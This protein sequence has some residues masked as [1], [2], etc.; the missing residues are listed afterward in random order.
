[1]K[2]MLLFGLLFLSSLALRACDICGGVS[3]NASIGLFA[4]SSF[5]MLGLKTQNQAFASYLNGIRH[6]REL[7][8]RHEIQGRIQVSKR[9][10]V[11][12]VI[13]YQFAWQLR[14]LGSDFRSGIGDPLVLGNAILLH[15]K[16]TTGLSKHFLSG[17]IGVK[18][19]LGA[20][21]SNESAL[22]NLYPGTGGFDGIVMMNYTKGWR[23]GWSL[24]NE[25]S[26]SIKTANKN[27]YRYGDVVQLASNVIKN[28]KWK[29]MRLIP[30][31]GFVFNHF[32]PS[33]LHGQ[34]IETSNNSGFVLSNK[35][36]LNVMTYK[37][38]FSMGV[39]IPLAQNV[40]K[41]ITK[42]LFSAEISGTYLL[43]FKKT[44]N[45]KI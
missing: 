12:A 6:S 1:M 21:G 32:K 36:T 14:D 38:L 40:N 39:Q 45:E 42:Q 41:G 23:N 18:F 20:F 19:P 13:P 22:M 17:A 27:G 37:W 11:M 34:Y 26:W 29:A 28:Q 31:L 5:H 24:Q 33:S 15:K 9:F 25:A 4:S 30:A 43:N 7:I 35:L 8:F 3:G 44:K 10:Q 2:N 16:D